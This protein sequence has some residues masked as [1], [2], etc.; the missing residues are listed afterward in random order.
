MPRALLPALLVC[1]AALPFVPFLGLPPISDDYSQWYFARLYISPSGLDG[2]AGD[3]LYRSRATSLVLTRLMDAVFGLWQPAHLAGGILLHGVNTVL[4]Y[5]VARGV[6]LKPVGAAL[7]AACFACYSGHQ[8]A[9]VWIASQ[10]ELLVF[11]FA[12]ATAL[13]WLRWLAGRGAVWGAATALCYVGALYSKES[14]VVVL[15]LLAGLAW[16]AR[17]EW[18]ATAAWLLPLSLI[19]VLY[20]AAI[21]QSA[22]THLHLNDGTF[23][24]QA[25][26]WLTLPGSL[27][28]LLWP[29]G[30]TALLIL[31]RPGD[32]QWRRLASGAVL[33]MV[34][35]L[36]PYVFLTY[37]TRV[38]SRHTYLASAGLAMLAGA[39]LHRLAGARPPVPRWTVPALWLLFACG[40][41]ANLWIRKLPSYEQRAQST[42][43]YL[44][45]AGRHPGPITIGDAPF[46]IT[47]YQHS[48][49][50]VFGRDPRSVQP[51]AQ[52]PATDS[53]LFVDAV[54]P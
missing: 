36:L 9:I 22:Q 14:A 49:A 53:T 26:F 3:V 43:R 20:T 5:L 33:W 48:A 50:I 2:L 45:F 6:G 47:F 1:L 31:V 16:A 28:R 11:T 23:S 35:A 19:T 18:R 17:A 39:A 8:E 52:G 7:G 15:P 38:P 46:P 41:V 4:L 44:E 30:V 34:L 12:A 25:P 54:H 27:L 10:H 40:N 51:L 24:W 42:Q 13:C 37:Q 32:R 29:A 21:F